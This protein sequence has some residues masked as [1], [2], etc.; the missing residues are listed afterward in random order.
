MNIAAPRPRPPERRV[1]IT[2]HMARLYIEDGHRVSVERGAGEAAGFIDDRYRQS[3]CELVDSA[4]EADAVVAVEPPGPNERAR[5]KPGAWLLGLL[6]P[7]DDPDSMQ[8]LAETGATAL[9]FETLPRTTRAQSMDVL[10]S[11]ATLAGYMMALEAALRVRRILPMMV[12]AAGT[13]RPATVVVLGCGVAGLQA[14]ATA[15]RLGAQVKGFDVRAAAAEQV[16]S[17][18]ASF[19]ELDLAPQDSSDSGGYARG[20]EED[21]QARMLKALEEHVAGADA[22]IT[23][24]AVPGRRAPTLV[25]AEAV[26]RMRPGSVVV[27]GAADRGGNC[28]LTAPDEVVEVGEVTVVGPTDLESS[29]SAD[30][31]RMFARNAYELISYLAA[32]PP[33]GAEDEIRAGVTITRGG[34][35][36]HPGVLDRLAGDPSG[37]EA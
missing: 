31:S 3:G 36:V 23:A 17:L 16:R 35:V 2:P 21:E 15:R 19:I 5:L 13:I 12:T 32:D 24:A 30:A 27:D 37:G 11:Q 6:R 14:I 34:E 29:P 22:V 26:A 7:L 25:T 33:P 10:S 18:G 20:L 4:W 8:A 28:V 1:G 9:A